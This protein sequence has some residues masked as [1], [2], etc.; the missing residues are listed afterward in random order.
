MGNEYS[1]YDA[2]ARFSE[3]IRKV[4]EGKVV[5]ISY[6]GRPVAEIRP[7][8][9]HGEGIDDHLRRL[10]ERGAIV[11]SKE[12]RGRLRPIARKRGALNRFL[13]E[14]SE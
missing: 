9:P 6:H 10:E 2:K 13:R 1:T 4:R 3:I 8:E 11:R 14:R 12:R 7:I 5:T